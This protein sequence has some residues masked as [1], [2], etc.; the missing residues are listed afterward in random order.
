MIKNNLFI[1]FLQFIPVLL[2]PF[3]GCQKKTEAQIAA[4][5]FAA[6]PAPVKIEPGIIDEASGI[7]DSRSND[8][9]IWVEQDSGNPNDIFLL[10]YSGT[11]LK[12]INIKS[13]V[14]RDW[15]DM[16]IGNGPVNGI[17]YLYLADIGDNSLVYGQCTIYR[18][19]EPLSTADTVTT[20]DEISFQYPDDPHDAEAIVTD[21]GSNDIFIITKRDSLSRIYKLAYP[22]NVAAMNTA[23][24]VGSLSFNGVVSATLSANGNELLVKT[25]STLYYWKKENNE[26]IE[27]LFRKT[28]VKLDYQ[29]EPQGEAVCFKKD[30]NGF[31]TLSERPPSATFV[32]L[33][34]Y[35]RK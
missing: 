31:Y 25:Y 27:Q 8:G 11:I 16:A 33:N 6:T 30:D 32:N 3:W 13:A 12:K 29:P 5:K 34:F 18:F 23:S 21:P 1:F 9:Y 20:Y 2:I 7:A 35:Q 17:N 15:E 10:A 24:Y 14:N 28:P 22:Q 19:P 4:V 26:S